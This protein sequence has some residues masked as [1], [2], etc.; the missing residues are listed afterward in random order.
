M[1]KLPKIY[2]TEINKKIS[3]NKKMCYLKTIT[4][5]SKKANIEN[6]SIIEKIDE[7]FSGLGYSYNKSLIIKTNKKEYD[8]SLIAKTKSSVITLENETI[9]IKDI[10]SIKEKKNN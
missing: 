1:K 6:E 2:Q 5:Q 7:I 9:P 8:T 4:E 10:I 3:N